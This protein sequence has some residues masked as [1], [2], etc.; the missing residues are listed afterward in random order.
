MGTYEGADTK[1][2]LTP[3]WAWARGG[4][5]TEEIVISVICTLPG[6]TSFL[7][8]DAETET[9]NAIIQQTEFTDLTAVPGILDLLE[10]WLFERYPLD[11]LVSINT[12]PLD[13]L[14][15]ESELGT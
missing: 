15:S 9:W 11:E 8:F 10:Q 5:D 2:L 12:D 4:D 3:F 7:G 6:R 1:I 13:F 14:S